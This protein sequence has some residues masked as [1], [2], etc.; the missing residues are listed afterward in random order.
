M[1]LCRWAL[2]RLA[3]GEGDE[4]SA[5]ASELGVQRV[6]DV[7][8]DEVFRAAREADADADADVA[9]DGE[10]FGDA[11]VGCVA[12]VEEGDD[13]GR[14][15]LRDLAAEVDAL[16]DVGNERAAAGEG[17]EA[18]GAEAGEAVG[19]ELDVFVETPA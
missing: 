3:A 4:Q 9:F 14:D 11:A 5:A 10:E 12:G 13:A 8:A 18:I 17:V 16:L 1:P 15:E 2:E 6:G 7:D 19:E